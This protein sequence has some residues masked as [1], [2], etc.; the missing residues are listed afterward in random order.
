MKRSSLTKV[1]ILATLLAVPGFLYYLLQEKGKNRYK[2]LAIY[3]DKKVAS[4]FH[5]RRGRKIPD[6]L[7]HT[8]RD[9]KLVNQ[10][11]D[12]VRFP[13]DSSKVTIVNFFYTSCPS[14]CAKMNTEMK[15]LHERFD[16]NR[17]LHFV[18]ITVDPERD[19]PEVLGRYARSFDAKGGEWD[20]LTGD[21]DLIYDLA[22]KD[23]LVDA[24]HDT[25]K[26]DGF[27]HSPML[28][29]VDSHKRI[30]GFYDTGRKESI[31]RL[32][33]EIKVLITEE[34]RAVKNR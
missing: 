32:T 28:I 17:L 8:I 9:F 30:R 31:D 34:L 22:R 24:L 12:T 11:G 5:T 15:R 23:F 29:L 19:N 18:S 33:D 2:T 27:I 4:T 10:L 25:T 21:T 1:L 6:T 7:Y 3:G 26:T 13:S 20:M 14:F 16:R